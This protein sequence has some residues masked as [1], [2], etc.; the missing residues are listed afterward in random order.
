MPESAEKRGVREKARRNRKKPRRKIPA[1]PPFSPLSSAGSADPALRDGASGSVAPGSAS[2]G[3]APSLPVEAAL[4]VPEGASEASRRRPRG[5]LWV[6]NLLFWVFALG[7]L[8]LFFGAKKQWSREVEAA[9]FT[10]SYAV[11]GQEPETQRYLYGET[12]LL[13]EAPTVPG[14]T[15]LGWETENGLIET[16]TEFPVRSDLTL[17]ARLLPAFETQE[18]IAY[19]PVQQEGILNP[20]GSVTV[21]DFVRI[22]AL[23]LKTDGSGSGRFLDVPESD[24]CFSA[25]AS[26]KDLGILSGLRLHPDSVLTRGEFFRMLCAFYPSADSDAVFQ[27]LDRDDPFYPAFCTAAANGWIPSGMLVQADTG[28]P[29][30]RAALARIMNRVLQRDCERHLDGQRTGT[31]LDV[32]P[33]DLDY[34]ALMEAAIPHSFRLEGDEEIWTDSTPF[35][36]HEPGYMFSGVRL[37]YIQEDGSPLVNASLGGLRFNSNGEITSGD[38]DLDRKL[39]EILASVID[40]ETMTREEMLRAVYDHVVHDYKY[41]YGNMYELG[42]QGWAVREAKRMLRN[43]GGNCYC[44]AALF[45]ELARFVGYDAVL[46]SGRVNGEQYSFQDYDG[47]FVYSREG[48]TPHGWVEIEIDGEYRIFDTEFE[49]RS[50]GL[51]DMFN[52]PQ[53]TR[54]QYGYYSEG[55]E[56]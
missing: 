10:V 1:R 16:R 56:S 31:A 42:A 32:S 2:P 36:I 17:T 35:P 14:M 39:F 20:N 8:V 19:L 27:D 30:T 34:D 18:H 50:Y 13:R 45:Y 48:S 7:L 51:Q 24:P 40:P 21:R 12:A 54:G 26:L 4:S 28:A 46:Y 15:F 9:T 38:A 11:P 43:G 41:I 52:C 22:L 3:S 37:H 47:N 23:L 53:T 25:A 5:L 6:L 55:P 33:A 44:F 49:F 29:V